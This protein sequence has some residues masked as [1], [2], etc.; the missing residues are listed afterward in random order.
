METLLTTANLIGNLKRSGLSNHYQLSK[1]LWVV[2]S[3]R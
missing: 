2:E 1:G 3:Y